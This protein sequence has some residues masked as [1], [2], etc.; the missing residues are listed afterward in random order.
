M[1]QTPSTIK[2][3][4]MMATAAFFAPLISTS[5]NKGFPPCTIYFVKMLTLSSKEQIL[6]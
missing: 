5:P 4:G 6:L 3:A 2:A 1:R